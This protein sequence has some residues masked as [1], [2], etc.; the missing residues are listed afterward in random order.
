MNKI[1]ISN[2][3]KKDLTND[4]IRVIQTNIK[5][6]QQNLNMLKTMQNG[7]LPGTLDNMITEIEVQI[8]NLYQQEMHLRKMSGLNH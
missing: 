3:S 4:K 5:V 1:Q 2:S 6:L 7:F 8:D